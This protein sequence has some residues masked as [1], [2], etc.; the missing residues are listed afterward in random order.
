MISMLLPILLVTIFE[1]VVPILIVNLF[2]SCS[3]DVRFVPIFRSCVHIFERLFLFC[4]YFN[5]FVPDFKSAVPVPI[6]IV[7]YLFFRYLSYSSRTHV[8]Y[9]PLFWKICTYVLKF[10]PGLSFNT[11]IIILRLVKLNFGT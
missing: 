3:L 4:S 6:L 8:S 5:D 1:G 10:G 9:V 2:S 7:L 11:S